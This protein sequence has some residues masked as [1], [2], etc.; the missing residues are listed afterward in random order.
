[1]EPIIEIQKMGLTR[2]DN[3][4]HVRYHSDVYDIIHA[5]DVTKLGLTIDLMNEWE[6]N[7]NDE[8]DINLEALANLNTKLLNEKDTERDKLVSFILN[9]VRTYLQSPDADEAKAAAQLDIA[10]HRYRGIQHESMEQETT[11]VDGLLIDLKKAD[12]TPLLAKLRLTAAVTLLETANAAFNQV[13]AARTT[14]RAEKDLP[15]AV[16]T[17]PKTD[18]VYERIVFLMKAAYLSGAT[19]IDRALITSVAKQ[20]NK[21]MDEINETFRQILAQRKAD[22]KKKPKDPKDPKPKDPKDPK[23]PDGGGDDIQIPSE[24][25]K[26]PEDKD[27]PKQPETGGGTGGSGDDIQ[28]PSEP[29]KKPDGQ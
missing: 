8:K 6:G 20:M 27:K 18:A 4:L 3:A 17:R 11:H 5:L 15:T 25:P 29:P 16:M 21:R 1:M 24:P 12:A 26:K 28:I 9:V 23:K 7:I 19:T 13:R 10:T 2:L 22:R 14:S